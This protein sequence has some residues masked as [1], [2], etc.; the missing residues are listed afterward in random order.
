MQ[1]KPEKVVGFVW[2]FFP[3][4]VCLVWGWFFFHSF[5]MLFFLPLFSLGTEKD[6]ECLR[7]VKMC[8]TVAFNVV[9]T[10]YI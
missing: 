8:I 4:F 1:R 3:C 10:S 6:R 9:E 7:S 2:F 5:Y